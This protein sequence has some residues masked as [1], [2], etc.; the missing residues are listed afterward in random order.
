MGAV[1]TWHERGIYRVLRFHTVESET[2]TS[3]LS[4]SDHPVEEGADITDHVRLEP[5]TASI[6]GRVSQKPTRGDSLTRDG[7]IE[8]FPMPLR[9]AV[10]KPDPSFLQG[11]IASTIGRALA[12]AEPDVSVTVLQFPTRQNF[13]EE[14]VAELL[15]LQR[16]KQL[17]ECVTSPWSLSNALIVNVT[18]NR[19]PEDGMGGVVQVDFKQIETVRLK[20]S[21]VPIAAEPKMKKKVNLGKQQPST[22][23]LNATGS[24]S[25][26]RRLLG[27]R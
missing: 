16:V 3:T 5:K 26:L 8:G 25:L 20:V 6:A 22:V 11:G 2:M 24:S 23:A 12:S 1:I 14:V 15:R 9:L 7:I 17:V 18:P 10:P 27:A 4:T 21:N 19:S 13:F